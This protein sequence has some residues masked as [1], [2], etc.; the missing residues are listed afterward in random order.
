MRV[1]VL[2]SP[3]APV[4]EVVSAWRA[5]QT[6]GLVDLLQVAS[7]DAAREALR[8]GVPDFVVVELQAVAVSDAGSAAMRACPCGPILWQIHR[9]TS[10]ARG[11]GPAARHMLVLCKRDNFLLPL[12]PS[13]FP[14]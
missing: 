2:S 14:R 3:K 5:A 13:L 12:T 10:G 11:G 1:L 6:P 7:L 9:G 8:A 4:V